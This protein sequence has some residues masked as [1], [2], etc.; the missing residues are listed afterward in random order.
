MRSYASHSLSLHLIC[1]GRAVSAQF[2]V[3][4]GDQCAQDRERL[5]YEVKRG[6]MNTQ[7]G[8]INLSDCFD[9]SPLVCSVYKA[10]W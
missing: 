10:F 1:L 5:S 7:N 6:H 4:E 9:I 8:Q 2:C 3:P